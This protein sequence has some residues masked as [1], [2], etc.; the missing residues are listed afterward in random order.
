MVI[1]A[2]GGLVVKV[3]APG[4]KG[5]TVGVTFSAGKREEVPGKSFGNKIG[6]D[7][8]PLINY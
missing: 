2:S 8:T 7:V 6:F 4:G 1:G 3:F 5:S